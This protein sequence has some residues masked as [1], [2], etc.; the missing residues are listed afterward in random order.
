MWD[1]LHFITQFFLLKVIIAFFYKF[2]FVPCGN[3]SKSNQLLLVVAQKASHLVKYSVSK[4]L[5]TCVD[6][7]DFAS[8]S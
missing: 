8:I 4:F 6:V 3:T 7:P 5:L 1:S 2:V